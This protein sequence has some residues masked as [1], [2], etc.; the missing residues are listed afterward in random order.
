MAKYKVKLAD[1]SYVAAFIRYHV[2]GVPQFTTVSTTPSKAAA[3]ALSYSMA[4][5]VAKVNHGIVTTA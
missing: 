1:G 2:P 5:T 4:V 3:P